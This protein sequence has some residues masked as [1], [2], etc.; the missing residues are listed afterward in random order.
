MFQK[1]NY[2]N[3]RPDDGPRPKLLSPCFRLVNIFEEYEAKAFTV[4]FHSSESKNAL[5]HIIQDVKF[6]SQ[7][8]ALQHHN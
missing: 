2:L 8:S 1:T 4:S 3:F 7:I 5:S 6:S